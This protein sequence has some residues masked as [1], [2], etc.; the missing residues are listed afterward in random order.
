MTAPVITVIGGDKIYHKQGVPYD[1][2]GAKAQVLTPDNTYADVRVKLVSSS[3]PSPCDTLGK[4]VVHYEA[5]G[6][7][8]LHIVRAQRTVHIG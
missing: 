3:V 8:G 6:P 1:D 7:H 4:Y 2:L 5:V